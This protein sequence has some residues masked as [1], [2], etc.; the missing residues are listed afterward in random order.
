[1][2]GTGA[3]DSLSWGRSSSSAGMVVVVAICGCGASRANRRML[4]QD[5]QG[6]RIQISDGLARTG[7][8]VGQVSGRGCAIGGRIEGLL[9]VLLCLAACAAAAAIQ[10]LLAE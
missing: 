2:D 7:D 1:M 9:S 3:A 10:R 8:D 4:S 6:S 5:R